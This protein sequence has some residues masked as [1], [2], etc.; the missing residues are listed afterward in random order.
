MANVLTKIL[1]D[2]NEREIKR[3]RLIVE[4]INAL[5]IDIAKLSDT[6]LKA[7]TSKLKADLAKGS[8]LDDILPEAFATVREASRRV[9][10]MRHFDVQLIGGLMLHRGQIAEMRTGEGKTLMAT[11][12]L[13]LNSL[14]G[15]GVHLVTV[16]DYL[17][18][19]GAGWMAPVYHF[20]GLSTGIIV[21]DAS[22]GV[23]G[24][25]YD[26]DFSDP[27][28]KDSRLEHLRPVSRREAYAA[29]I[30]YGTNNEFGFDYLRDNMVDSLD[31]MVQRKLNFAI[32]DEADSILI[33]EART[34]LIISAPADE[35]TDQYLR[36]AQIAK[37]L[38]PE[39]HYLIDE[40]LKAVSLT[41]DGVVEIERILGV[42]NVYEAGRIEDVHHIE[43]SLRAEAMYSLDKDYVVRDGEIIIVDEF[44]GRL[45]PGRRWSEGL[46]QAVEAK[47]NVEIKQESLTLATITFQNYFRLYKKLS[48]MTGTALTESEEFHKIYNLGVVT[49]PTNKTM[50]RKDLGDRIYK[51]EAGKFRA[52][53]REVA[54]RN[55]T[56]QPVLIGTVSI[57]KNELLSR[58]LHEL[59]VPHQ[60]LNA[61]NNEAEASIVSNAG[62]RGAV[63]L[64]TN[65]AGRG[66][67]IVLAEG[68]A[69]LGGLHVLGTERHEARR[70]DNQLRGRSGRQGDP[71]STQFYVSLEDDLM[72]IF[73]SERL[74]G[75]MTSLG[76]DEDTPIENGIVSRSLESAQKKV[77]GYNFD[78]RKQLVEYDDVMNRHR[79]VV[80]AR[81]R[82]ALE[83]DRMR[84]EIEAMTTKQ[85]EAMVQ[86][87]TDSRTGEVDGEALH[88]AVANV[89]PHDENLHEIMEK[90]HPRDLPEVLSTEAARIYDLREAQYGED[91]MKLLERLTYINVLDRLWIEH[92]E[93]MD[94]LRGGIGLRAIGQRDPLVEYKREGFRMFQQFIGFLE[95]EIA[96]SIFKVSLTREPAEA[97][98]IETVL[99]RAAEQASTNSVDA[100]S[101]SSGSRSERRSRPQNVGQPK[102]TKSTKKKK[103]R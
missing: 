48:G 24:F 97:M 35:A 94:N 30:T 14:T 16:N 9:N 91:G 83:S 68:V 52:V 39:E 43:Q 64:A 63:T 72:R 23:A 12:P 19:I 13:Y 10:N 32:V 58:F 2:P 54:E 49:I 82:K 103:R 47:E 34:P 20:L 57:A 50:I 98:P 66:T 26:P 87:H 56:G 22:F 85:F 67:D 55:A 90:A 80:Y 84:E 5:E 17:T 76:L 77:E 101:G 11:L 7:Q 100:I 102:A 88:A 37:N 69:E 8:S 4:Q 71:G 89:L 40:K 46:H 62:A 31:R 21:P 81:R 25:M 15:D 36:F 18:R 6:Q 44:T 29:D 3:S 65:I 45:M 42:D 38:K 74:A 61:K 95:G 28:A 75:V 51:T 99:T 1:G 60:V 79:E 41:D 86:A 93:A 53:A 96:S 27:E 73:G 92:L 70:I 78:T 33:D 59:K